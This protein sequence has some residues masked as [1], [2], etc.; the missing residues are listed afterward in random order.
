MPSCWP[1]GLR[2]TGAGR[3]GGL[4][5]GLSVW[6]L[7]PPQSSLGFLQGAGVFCRVLDSG[8]GQDQLETSLEPE[9]KGALLAQRT[10]ARRKITYQ[11][12]LSM[13]V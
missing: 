2:L 7:S 5:E 12:A 9:G 13:L 4:A 11:A 8:W 3:E 6:D 10:Q 1:A